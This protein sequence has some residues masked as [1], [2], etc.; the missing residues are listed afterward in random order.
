M[1]LEIQNGADRIARRSEASTTIALLGPTGAGKTH[2]ARTL[3]PESSLFID[4]EAGTLS[5]GEWPGDVIDVRK[6][7][8]DLG[9]HPWELSR[10]VACWLSGPDPAENEGPYSAAEYQ[11]YKEHLGDPETL[12]KYDNVFV[13]SITVASRHCFSWCQQQ[14]ENYSEKTG[15]LDT[16]SVYGH[17]G[18]EL[19]SWL[20]TLQHMK[21]NIIV[22]CILDKVVDDMQRVSYVPQIVGGMAGKA[23]PGIFDNVISL[24]IFTTE[25]GKQ[26]RAF[27]CHTMNQWGYPAKNRSGNV[28]QLEKPN[29]MGLIQKIRGVSAVS[30]KPTD[31]AIQTEPETQDQPKESEED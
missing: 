13:D 23:L 29:L 2:S 28:D 4:L 24:D 8:T 18:R 7:A 21:K 10:A 14:P 3:P 26:Y 15:K 11:V 30:A 5:L 12:K 31:T 25:E 19:T 16:R 20:T 1:P 27:V 17:V 6:Q 9:V 22:A